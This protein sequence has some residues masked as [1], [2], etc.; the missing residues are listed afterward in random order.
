M[1]FVLFFGFCCSNF[2]LK[3]WNASW[4]CVSSLHRGH[5]NLLCIV[6]I[7]VHKLPEWAQIGQ[8]HMNCSQWSPS[9][10]LQTLVLM[11]T[12]I[13]DRRIKCIRTIIKFVG[14]VVWVFPFHSRYRSPLFFFLFSL[15]QVLSILLI[16]SRHQFLISLIFSPVFLFILLLISVLIFIIFFLLLILS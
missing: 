6:P 12:K 3:V 1:F 7:S 2:P 10:F 13:K 8:F 9:T 5:A 4:I 15:N 16:F 14:P 11:E